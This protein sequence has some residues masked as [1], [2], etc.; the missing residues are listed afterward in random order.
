MVED[1]KVS[2]V[3]RT[4]IRALK[5]ATASRNIRSG[6]YFSF[7]DSPRFPHYSGQNPEIPLYAHIRYRSGEYATP[8]VSR[9]Q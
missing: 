1:F 4:P 9:Q 3:I 8:T 7:A 6:G 5:A 2:Q